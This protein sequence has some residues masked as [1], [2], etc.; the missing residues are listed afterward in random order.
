M[1]V[2]GMPASGKT[3]LAHTLADRHGLAL[4]GKDAIK[5]PLMDVLGSDSFRSRT[6]SDAAFAVMFRLAAQLLDAGLDVILEGNFRTE[7]ETPLS[8]VSRSRPVLQILCT[9]PE[10]QRHA[11]ILARADDSGRHPGH[12]DVAQAHKERNTGTQSGEIGAVAPADASGDF[13]DLPGERL[14]FPTD[15]GSEGAR[16]AALDRLASYLAAP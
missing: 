15:A 3:T 12:R 16:D 9:V 5:E 10:E 6:L 13:L 1:L 11:R 2:T 4:I 7:H 14:V 8:A